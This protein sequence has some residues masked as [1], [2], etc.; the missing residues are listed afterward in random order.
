MKKEHRENAD[1]ENAG[2]VNGQDEAS[3]APQHGGPG[4]P[5]KKLKESL[6]QALRMRADFENMKKRMEKERLDAIKYANEGLLV[7]VLSVTD[8]F[9]RAMASL[10]EGHDVEKVKQGLEIAQ[11]Q[12]HKVLEQHGVEIVKA[13]GVDFDPRVHEAVAVVPTDEFKEGAIVDEIQKG[14][15]LNGRLI[16]PSRVRVAQKK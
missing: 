12:L 13:Q 1:A 4:D 5:E 2:A 3:A 8:N 15:L 9:D 16:R 6:E 7:D 10:A 14:Y 11:Q